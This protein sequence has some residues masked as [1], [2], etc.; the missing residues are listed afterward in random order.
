MS[1]RAREC[2]TFR[3]C[4]SAL[5]PNLDMYRY[6]YQYRYCFL[7]GKK[8]TLVSA[9]SHVSPAKI[10]RHDKDDIWMSGRW[11]LCKDWRQERE[12]TACQ[13]HCGS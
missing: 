9:I 3:N 6:R 12:K 13:H 11:L 2:Q 4:R 1:E 10:V 5:G 7:L 8:I